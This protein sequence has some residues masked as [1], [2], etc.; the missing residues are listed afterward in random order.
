MSVILAAMANR[1]PHGFAFN[2]VGGRRPSSV[3]SRQSRTKS[4]TNDARSSTRSSIRSSLFSGSKS[5]DTSRKFGSG[6]SMDK[7][8]TSGV[9][10]SLFGRQVDKSPSN[11]DLWVNVDL[12]RSA[13]VPLD[14]LSVSSTDWMVADTTTV[15]TPATSDYPEVDEP[16][17]VAIVRRSNSVRPATRRPLPMRVPSMPNQLESC[18]ETSTP[19]QMS[20][21]D[22]DMWSRHVHSYNNARLSGD[23]GHVSCKYIDSFC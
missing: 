3:L 14:S 12:H 13:S 7:T 20:V 2:H 21:Q 1:E 18:T 19:D 9:F 8:P 17:H 22:T 11:G 10:R 6:T 15:A 23:S 5:R 4:A 16:G